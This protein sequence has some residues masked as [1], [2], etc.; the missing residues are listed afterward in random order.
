MTDRFPRSVA[1]RDE[2][3]LTA[4]EWLLI[5]AADASPETNASSFREE[6]PPASR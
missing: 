1:R 2:S 6:S 4:L 5:V 3:G